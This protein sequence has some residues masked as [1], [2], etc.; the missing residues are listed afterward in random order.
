MPLTTATNAVAEDELLDVSVVLFDSGVPEGEVPKEVVEE[1]IREGTFVQIRR[2]ESVYMSALLRQTLQKT[3]NW[4][5]VWISPKPT[6]AADV[7]VVGKILHSDGDQLRLSVTATDSTGRVW[8]DDKPYEMETAAGAFNR[9]RYPDLDPYQDAFNEIANDLALAQKKLSGDDR[10]ALRTVTSLR[11]AADLSPEA[12]NGY[13][14][15]NKGEYSLNRLPAVDDPMYDRTQR[16][17]QRERLFLD[18]LDTHYSNFQAEAMAPYDS[19]REYTREEAIAVRELTKS[20]RW[21]TGM[22]IAAIVASIAYGQSS[23]ANQFSDR[24]LRDALMYVGVDMIRASQVRKQEKRLHTETLEELA[25][26]FDDSIEPMVVEVQGTQHRLTGTA[27]AQY[28]EWRQLLRQ[29]FI[30]ESGFVPEDVAIYTEPPAAP[31]VE[32]PPTP[33]LA[34]EAAAAEAA[35]AAADAAGVDGQSTTDGAAAAPVEGQATTEAADADPST[36]DGV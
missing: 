23:D 28:E 33:E 9:Q 12:F 31:P 5:S 11:Y 19:W 26:D 29:I 35:A 2:S 20:A 4:G 10:K 36:G 14:V 17:R 3:G 32:L 24:M 30:S 27:D 1:L 34:A 18:T 22:G 21:R 15:E 16:V 13:V 6:V 7:N 25:Q 8:L